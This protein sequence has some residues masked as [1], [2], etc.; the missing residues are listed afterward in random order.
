LRILILNPHGGIVGGTETYLRRLIPALRSLQHQVAFLYEYE[1]PESI[2]IALEGIQTWCVER[3][4]LQESVEEASGWRPDIIFAHGLPAEDLEEK[5][6][7]LAPG[8]YFIH[9]YFG[10]CIS[11]IKA[12]R[13]PVIQ[14]CHKRL[15]WPCLLHYLPRRCGGLNPLTMWSE[16][17][18]QLRR[19]SNFSR[20]NLLI[21]HSEAMRREYLKHGLPEEKVHVVPMGLDPATGAPNANLNRKAPSGMVNLLFVG[22]MEKPKGGMY[23]LEAVQKLPKLLQK[24]VRLTFAGDG[25]ERHK[26]E[27]KAR[28]I[29]ARSQEIQVHFTGWIGRDRLASL[30]SETDLLVVPSLW[31]E[32]FGLI[33]L[34]AAQYGVPAVAYDVGGVTAWLEDGVNG[35]LAPGDP[36]TPAGLVAAMYRALRDPDQYERLR[37]GAVERTRRIRIEDHAR[38]LEALFAR[39]QSVPVNGRAV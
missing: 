22:R 10:V 32:P 4:G 19:L 27:E 26:W 23:L 13:F 5:I 36:P 12:H 8:V 17:Q 24:P 21:T 3:L 15:G 14:P 30:F 20:Y 9:N 28:R 2:N 25:R 38:A 18:K 35:C 29:Q 7:K 1:S 39:M 11:G 33:G 37:K 6:L 31:P 34:E 16:Y